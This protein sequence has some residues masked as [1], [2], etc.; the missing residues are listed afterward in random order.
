MPLAML[1]TKRRTPPGVRELKHQLNFYRRHLF[2]RTPP[3]VRELKLQLNLSQIDSLS[4]TPPGVRELK[5]C[6]QYNGR[7]KRWSHPSRG[8]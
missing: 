3:G 7:S 1:S 5:P 6:Y 2:S 4:R 8:A